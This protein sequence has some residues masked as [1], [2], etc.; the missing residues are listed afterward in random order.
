MNNNITTETRMQRIN[1]VAEILYDMLCGNQQAQ[2]LVEI[3]LETSSNPP[4]QTAA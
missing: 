3:I 2:V 4:S 1:T